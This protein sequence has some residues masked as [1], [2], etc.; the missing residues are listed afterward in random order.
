MYLAMND[1]FW[2]TTNG[3][4]SWTQSSSDIG[5]SII[6]EIAVHPTDPLKIAIASTGNQKVYLSTNGGVSW[7]S[8]L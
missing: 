8:Q 5:A 3:G 2:Y 4:T 7:T 6:N 1:D